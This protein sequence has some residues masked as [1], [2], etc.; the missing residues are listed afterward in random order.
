MTGNEPFTQNYPLATLGEFIVTRE[1]TVRIAVLRLETSESSGVARLFMITINAPAAVQVALWIAA[2]YGL[3]AT[4]VLIA[5]VYRLST[6]KSRL[7]S[8]IDNMTQGLLLF[9]AGKRVVICNQRYIDLYGLSPDIVKPGCSL[10]EVLLHRRERGSLIGDVDAYCERVERELTEG[11]K[12]F[13]LSLADGRSIQIIDRPMASGGW[14][15]THEDITARRRVDK[16]IEDMAHRD[17]LTGL[18][19]RGFFLKHLNAEF[20]V[21]SGAQFALLFI[22]VDDFKNVNDTLGHE[23]GDE[24]LRTVGARLRTCAPR[25]TDFVARLGGDEFVVI[26]RMISSVGEIDHLAA[27]IISQLHEPMQC[28]GECVLIDVSIG[29]GISPDHGGEAST[30]MRNADIAMYQAKAAGKRTWKLYN[31]NMTTAMNERRRIE[32]DLRQ[33]ILS[34]EMVSCG[35]ALSFQ[36]L[37][38][39]ASNHVTSCEALLR[40]HHPLLGPIPPEKVIAI[41]EDCRLMSELGE[42]VLKEALTAA[43][44]WPAHVSVAVNVSTSQFNSPPFALKVLNALA[45]SGVS[46]H[47]LELEI[48]E[49]VFVGDA[50]A[51]LAMLRQ[52]QAASVRVALDDFGTGY[53]SLNYLR[54]FPFDKIKI[55]RCFIED[56]GEDSNSIHI[57]RAIVDIARAQQMITTAE[58]VETEVQRE[59]LKRLG[60]SEMQGLLFSPA[61]SAA[62]VGDL[63]QASNP[64]RKVS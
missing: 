23:A 48:T 57:V 9:D 55:D 51:P 18:P 38:D 60:C 34:D 21:R 46:P 17:S 45:A 8:A 1:P 52:L 49:A 42:W 36:P 2:S 61:L 40:W 13:I 30:L 12:P 31:S 44:T 20:E 24:L 16:Q 25:E 41:A 33:A 58:G 39:L 15:S 7:A 53:S 50:V 10:R 26:R 3:V 22:D 6:Q 5:L 56:I 64:T 4:V 29:I 47:R 27:D 62:E 32:S 43:I 35:F 63:L 11:G 28:S 37:V 14:V 54:S 59:A 19:N